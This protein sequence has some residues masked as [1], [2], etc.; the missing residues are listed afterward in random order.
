MRS[1]QFLKFNINWKINGIKTRCLKLQLSQTE[2]IRNYLDTC[3]YPAFSFVS[4][5]LYSHLLNNDIDWCTNAN[6][7]GSRLAVIY[8][9]ELK[10]YDIHTAKIRE[11]IC[12]S[13]AQRYI[14][15]VSRNK[16]LGRLIPKRQLGFSTTKG[17]FIRKAIFKNN[18]ILIPCNGGNINKKSGKQQFLKIPYKILY[19]KNNKKEI[20][21]KEVSGNLLYNKLSNEFLFIVKSDL[22]IVWLYQPQKFLGIDINKN[23]DNYITFS[24]SLNDIQKIVRPILINKLCKTLRFLNQLLLKDG[25]NKINTKQR[26]HIRRAWF[27]THKQIKNKL[28]QIASHIIDH[29]IK[30]KICLCIDTAWTGASNG[31]YGQEILTILVEKC[32]NMGVPFVLVPSPYTSQRCASCGEQHIRNTKT[33]KYYCSGCG[34]EECADINGAKNIV[35]FGEKIWNDGYEAFKEWF[36]DITNSYIKKTP[37]TSRAGDEQAKTTA[38][39]S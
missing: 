27:N 7:L 10:Q 5:K 35:Y 6:M 26:R 32:E 1:K 15:Y 39:L 4:H 2:I 18:N 38:V 30:N 20:S 13:V 28:S 24:E 19:D 29:A 16:K 25:K 8:K 33:N 21:T 23:K 3:F 14:S 11:N 17:T 9:E 34:Y 22:K 12:I 36:N 31:E 37:V